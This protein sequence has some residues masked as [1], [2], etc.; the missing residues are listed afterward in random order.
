MNQDHKLPPANIPGR[1]QITT[2][3]NGDL[4]RQAEELIDSEKL[5]RNIFDNA[6]IGMAIGFR[7]GTF[8]HAN[9]ACHRMLGYEPGGLIGVHRSAV[10]PPEDVVENEERYRRFLE[11][12]QGRLSYEKRYMRKDGRVIWID[13]DVSFIRDA[14]GKAIFSIIMVRDITEHKRIEKQLKDYKEHLEKLV[15]ERTNELKESEE[16]FRNIFENAV[17]G[18][19]QSTPE[20]RFLRV[21]PAL[22]K[23]YGYESPEELIRSVTNIATDIYADPDRRKG[24]MDLARRDGV[25]RNFELQVRTRDGSIK[26][27]SVNAHTV[28]D[29]NGK[30]CYYEGII[31]DI[32]EKKFASDQLVAQ[33][34]L[35]L[36]LAQIDKLEEGL[37][38][39]LQ[40]AI[41]TSGMECG[42]VSLKNPETSS[43]DLVFSMGLPDEFSE[44][45]R[46]IMPG[47]TNWSHMMAGKVLHI[48]PSQELTPLAYEEGYKHIS[49]VPILWHEEVIGT[50]VVASK[51]FKNIPN[52]ARI[53]LE[54]L[55]TEIGNIVA[56]MQ[57]RQ[58][59]DEEIAIRTETDKALKAEHQSVQEANTALKVLLNHREEDRKELEKKV[60][61]NMQ[62]LV[63]PHIEKLKKNSLDPVQQMSI[64]FI[65][66][67]LNEILSPF[68]HIMQG[69]K[70][71]P[72]Q[73]EVVTL[74]KQ[75]RTTKE[76]ARILNMS[77]QAVDI[78]R[79]MI[80]KK[81]GLN[82]SKTNLQSYLK[83][84]L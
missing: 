3:K 33:R 61:A 66:S 65:E 28:K 55:A 38:V 60:F 11:T 12:G 51:G 39:I 64:S 14:D 45:I 23:M 46:H 62:Q 13:M 49:I 25:V 79:F 70:F 34:D 2:Q 32:T 73:L 48:C 84:L 30:I 58:R 5:F 71:T 15:E 81:L 16:K 52:Q 72:R 31:Q 75:G 27:V 37:A 9:A 26:Y 68:L 53:G 77:K 82:K 43:F 22:A 36:K 21:N 44:K 42:G 80:R 1:I 74:I 47:A 18:I 10:T 19:Y 76:I 56:R 63:M 35:A 50:L 57:T 6:S 7:D 29:G 83:S 40:T 4:Y 41:N 8:V 78:Q 67:N 20:G 54:Y 24:F 59:L 17:M 69:F